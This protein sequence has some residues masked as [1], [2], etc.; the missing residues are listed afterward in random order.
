MWKKIMIITFKL[1]SPR[2]PPPP[3]QHTP[4]QPTMTAQFHTSSP[5]EDLME[6]FD[7][8]DNW[9]EE[10]APTGEFAP[11]ISS[12]IPDTTEVDNFT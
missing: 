2:V 1:F 5:R 6:F 10:F 3:P 8:K 11:T 9:G 4:A 12:N 7:R